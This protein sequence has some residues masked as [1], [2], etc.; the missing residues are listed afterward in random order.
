LY[1]LAEVFSEYL[2]LKSINVL[3]I[4][5]NGKEAVELQKTFP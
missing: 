1:D 5:S 3:A 2:A 4:G